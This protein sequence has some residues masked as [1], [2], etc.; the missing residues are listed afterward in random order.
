[1]EAR[2]SRALAYNAGMA[3]NQSPEYI[4]A[5]EK[6]RTATTD[7]VRLAALQEMLATV[8]K[9]KASEKLQ[10]DLKTRISTL[11]KQMAK[12]P[13]GPKKAVDL[14]HVPKGGA[15][16]IV[17]IGAPNCGKSL[18]VATT[19]NAPVKVA[20]YPYTT[21]V[22]APGMWKFEDV[23]LQLVDTP[24]LTAESVPG[25]LMGTIRAAEVIVIVVD[26]AGDLL[27]EAEMVTGV[28]A[29]R[30]VEPVSRSRRLSLGL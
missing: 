2:R 11:K 26:A 7:D 21:T 25:G 1:M 17:L 6:Y 19:T 15:G 8:P 20:E 16:Q 3:T 30:G 27:E 28:L 5:E 23:Q 13:T 22:P 4:R 14:F 9:H 29:A 18:L 12:G 10:A 24:P